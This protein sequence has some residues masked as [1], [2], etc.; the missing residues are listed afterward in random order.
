MSHEAD[1]AL[2]VHADVAADVALSGRLVAEDASEEAAMGPVLIPGLSRAPSLLLPDLPP[3]ASVWLSVKWSVPERPR[4]SSAHMAAS[5]AALKGDSSSCWRSRAGVTAQLSEG[6]LSA[7][8]HVSMD[9]LSRTALGAVY[10][11][12]LCSACGL[13]PSRA[14]RAA[15]VAAATAAATADEDNSSACLSPLSD[16]LCCLVAAAVWL[17]DILG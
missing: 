14:C 13:T 5:C 2:D 4:E 6:C 9:W 11:L 12:L 8:R 16:A 7:G 3:V 10:R 1:V 15:A 17:F